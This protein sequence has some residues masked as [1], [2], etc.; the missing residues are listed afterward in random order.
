MPHNIDTTFG[1]TT[2]KW[3][4]CTWHGLTNACPTI[5]TQPS[6][7]PRSYFKTGQL[8]REGDGSITEG[9]GQGRVTG[10]L[11][12]TPIDYSVHIPDIDSVKMTFR[13]L[14]EEGILVGA[15]SGLNVCAA[16]QVARDLGPGHSVATILCDNG[17]RYTIVSPSPLHTCQLLNL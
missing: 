16:V 11:Q 3:H 2:H 17:T 1:A 10:N 12:D 15:S 13:L 9:I 4:A 5:L 6:A 7:P 14:H 8:D